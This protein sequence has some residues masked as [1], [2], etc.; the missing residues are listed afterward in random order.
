M[1]LNNITQSASQNLCSTLD[2]SLS[3][4]SCVKVLVQD[5]QMFLEYDLVSYNIDTSNFQLFIL[6]ILISVVVWMI[7]KSEFWSMYLL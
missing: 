6:I 1:I 7:E 3:A 4:S 2:F 5:V